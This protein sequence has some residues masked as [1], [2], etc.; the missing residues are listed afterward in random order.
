MTNFSH[1]NCLFVYTACAL[2]GKVFSDASGKCQKIL[3][4]PG[5]TIQSVCSGMKPAFPLCTD[6][7]SCGE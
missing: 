2:K 6:W 7:R 4:D 3:T 1:V 5:D